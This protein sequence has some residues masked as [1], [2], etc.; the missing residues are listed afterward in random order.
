MDTVVVQAL[1]DIVCGLEA[2]AFQYGDQGPL[3]LQP[4]LVLLADALSAMRAYG[5]AVFNEMQG[6]DLDI[7]DCGLCSQWERRDK[8]RQLRHKHAEA[9]GAGVSE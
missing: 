5:A 4:R 3:G 2:K 1:A 8:Q 6:Y 9:F 7:E